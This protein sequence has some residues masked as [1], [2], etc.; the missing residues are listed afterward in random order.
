M[1]DSPQPSSI[2]RL[3]ERLPAVYFRQGVDGSY[4]HLGGGLEQLLGLS[5][6]ELLADASLLAG[7]LRSEGSGA[8]P[9]LEKG[10]FP[11]SG[12]RVFR[13]WNAR[14]GE[15]KSIREFR[16]SIQVDK[17]VVGYEGL[18]LDHSHWELIERRLEVGSWKEILCRL[19]QGFTH[20]L[21][22]A[23]TGLMAMSELLVSQADEKHPFHDAVNVVRQSTLK[24]A[25]LVRR[26]NQLLQSAPGKGEFSDAG[27]VLTESLEL[28]H[29][30]IPR[31][32]RV[33][34]DLASE[35]LPVRADAW[36]LRLLLMH[37]VTNALEA[38]PEG[39]T[40]FIQA[41]RTDVAPVGAPLVGRLAG[42]PWVRLSISDT[43]PAFPLNA[44]VFEA[45]FGTKSSQA[46]TGLGLFVTRRFCELNNG[47]L[48]V[49]A[50]KGL[51]TT[52]ELWLQL[53]DLNAEESPGTG[54][55]R[56]LLA[57]KDLAQVSEL[58]KVCRT[59]GYAAVVSPD[60]RNLP[61]LLAVN[62]SEFDAIVLMGFNPEL[63]ATL[64][65]LRREK[66]P[67][68][69]VVLTNET[70]PPE[71]DLAMPYTDPETFLRRLRTTLDS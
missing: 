36:R 3:L 29:K 48:F 8:L 53:V 16:T 54:N 9:V 1:S 46:G 37:L 40:L 58:A 67:V 24:A 33:K 66:L 57:G 15:L 42:G 65:W 20:D 22:N 39:G 59:N 35:P 50:T 17:K 52:A 2:E 38:M 64:E 4:E 11:E 31:R 62:A 41:V 34:Q 7:A 23:L 19:T 45:W 60:L 18:W 27:I 5:R 32:V 69:K 44:E 68:F 25:D 26:L 10:V 63:K 49:A 51:G 21:N 13:L 12:E 71:A 6:S 47:A 30:A 56:L 70:E 28:L 14:S 43:G 61:R 55:E